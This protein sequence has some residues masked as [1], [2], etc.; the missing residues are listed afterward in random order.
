MDMNLIVCVNNKGVIGRNNDLIY[1]IKNDMQN[2]R[3]ITLG[4]TVIMGSK[5]FDSLPNKPLKDRLNIVITRNVDKYGGIPNVIA[6][7]SIENAIKAVPDNITTFIIGGASI[8][9]QFLDKG[10]VNRIILTEVD[11]DSEEKNDAKILMPWRNKKDDWMIRFQTDY[12]TDSNNIR[13]R[14]T[15][16]DK[17]QLK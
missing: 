8:Y 15:I 14:Y 17:K 1:H 2:F 13:Y 5:T 16:Y 3:R 12:I 6:V 9:N 7:E 11:D 10:N 4:K